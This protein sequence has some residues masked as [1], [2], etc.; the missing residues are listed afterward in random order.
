MSSLALSKQE[1]S[2]CFIRKRAIFRDFKIS[3]LDIISFLFVFCLL[4]CYSILSYFTN[5]ENNTQ[6]QTNQT[7]EVLGERPELS[8][9]LLLYVS[10]SH[11]EVIRIKRIISGEPVIDDEHFVLLFSL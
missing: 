10:K 11:P 3:K 8:K 6:L 1:V 5:G 9:A 2:R 7:R 4:V